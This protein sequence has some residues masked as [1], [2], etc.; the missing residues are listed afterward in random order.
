MNII[1]FGGS[2]VN[3]DGKYDNK[4]ISE[5]IE[6]VRSSNDSFIFVVGGGKICRKVQDAAKPFL[7]EALN[8]DKEVGRANDWLGSAVTWINGEYVIKKFKESL[9]EE[10]HP[11]LIDN[12]TKKIKSKA[13]IFFTGA[14]KPGCSTDKDMML[15]AKTFKA[16]KVF[17]ISDFEIVKN[18]RPLDLAKLSGEEKLNALKEAKEISEMSWKELVRLVG[19]EW[20]PGLSTPFDPQAAALGYKLRKRLTV[21]IGRKEQ[22][23][24]MLRGEE[25]RGTVV[26]G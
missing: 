6:L 4:V 16:E 23:P 12:P 19:K 24:K 26:R 7:I 25:F 15:L 5:F 14:W 2:I 10:V 1:K 17:K 18:I 13:R 3:P 22:I 21:Y 9:G 8:D 20:N 11:E